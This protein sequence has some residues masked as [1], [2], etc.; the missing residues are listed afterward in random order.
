MREG[1][2]I[3]LTDVYFVLK[4]EVN[5]ENAIAYVKG[6][7]TYAQHYEKLLFRDR[8]ENP[9]VRAA[10]DRIRRLEV[11]VSYP[12]LLECY[13]DY[14]QSRITRDDFLA[15]LGTI[16]NFMVRRFVCN[17]PTYGL[18]RVFAPLYAQIKKRAQ[19]HLYRRSRYS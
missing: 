11:G 10:L 18:N 9:E 7:A 15:T 17:V 1:A 8:E 6:L 2:E 3:K 14:S 4:D 5:L 12:F 16:E 13:E 19:R